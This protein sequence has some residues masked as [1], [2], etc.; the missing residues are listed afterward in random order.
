MVKEKQNMQRK[1][2]A[3]EGTTVKLHFVSDVNKGLV[4]SNPRAMTV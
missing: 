2:W 3:M 1:N 4:V